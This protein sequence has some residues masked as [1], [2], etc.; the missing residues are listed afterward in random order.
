VITSIT[1]DPITDGTVAK[2]INVPINTW[3]G[4][5]F[6]EGDA[7]SW[8]GTVQRN[9]D[10]VAQ[11]GAR[12]GLMSLGGFSRDAREAALE[13]YFG[14]DYK[15]LT[16]DEANQAYG[17]DGLRFESPIREGDAAL[18]R[19]R[20]DEALNLAQYEQVAQNTGS[21]WIVGLG[22]QMAGQMSNPLDFGMAVMPIFAAEKIG[23][24][25]AATVGWR[26][27]LKFGA[28]L[29]LTAIGQ[30]GGLA[31]F[32]A[33]GF[34]AKF[35]L[36]TESVLNGAT[37]SAIGEISVFFDQKALQE[38]TNYFGNVVAGAAS[39]GA[40]HF[41]LRLL[42]RVLE[43][44]ARALKSF[45]PETHEAAARRAASTFERG[46][47]ISADADAPLAHAGADE[48]LIRQKAQAEAFNPEALR[49]EAMRDPG[50]VAEVKAEIDAAISAMQKALKDGD[51]VAA[52]RAAQQLPPSEHVIASGADSATAAG[53]LRAAIEQLPDIGRIEVGGRTVS[54]WVEDVSAGKL[55]DISGYHR[56]TDEQLQAIAQSKRPESFRANAREILEIRRLNREFPIEKRIGEEREARV[57]AF[58]ESQSP[59]AKAERQQRIAESD[60]QVAAK[61]T[62]PSK[63][64]EEWSKVLGDL[65][66]EKAQADAHSTELERQLREQDKAKAGEGEQSKTTELDVKLKKLKDEADFKTKIEKAAID[67]LMKGPNA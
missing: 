6:D 7:H 64:G 28:D 67:C 50:V 49:L 51:P 39:A 1:P 12:V 45:T 33:T 19:T 31:T 40:F 57:K 42:G 54:R 32:K 63:Q 9:L 34:A 29:P 48:N 44:A 14:P 23:V 56:M 47:S 59:A 13:E 65:E 24:Q 18:R 8:Q 38:P 43:P 37:S 10:R 25:A 61:E 36:F 52:V 58:V 60:A 17:M 35:P 55:T 3:W 2:G 20:H 66:K 21:L 27:A 30:R 11:L 16:P 5:N 15:T 46:E 4:L 62:A 53:A 22:A 26:S 41:S